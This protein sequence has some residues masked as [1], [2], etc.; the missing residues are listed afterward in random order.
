MPVVRP[1]TDEPH[2]ALQPLKQ[3]AFIDV[4]PCAPHFSSGL[5]HLVRSSPCKL[6]PSQHLLALPLYIAKSCRQDFDP[7]S[8]LFAYAPCSLDLSSPLL[9]P[10]HLLEVSWPALELDRVVHYL[11]VADSLA[12]FAAVSPLFCRNCLSS[13]SR[14]SHL[15]QASAL[16]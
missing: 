12:D 16:L 1:R 11:P 3:M 10:A 9:P 5:L 14:P 6:L 13:T 4:T 7:L 8:R 2:Y 15:C